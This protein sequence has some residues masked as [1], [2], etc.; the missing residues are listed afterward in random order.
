VFVSVAPHDGKL[1]SGRRRDQ[2]LRAVAPE[3]DRPDG[4]ERVAAF[5]LRPQLLI[6]RSVGAEDTGRPVAAR[7]VLQEWGSPTG[8]PCRLDALAKDREAD[9]GAHRRDDPEPNDDLHLRPC[10]QLEMVVDWGHQKDAPP[11]RAV[12]DHLNQ[13]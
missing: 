10:L 12:R 1:S 9:R 8:T 5:P 11:R 13:D 4:Q 3:C 7:Y 6:A 2:P